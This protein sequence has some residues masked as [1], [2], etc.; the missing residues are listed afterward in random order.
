VANPNGLAFGIA[1]AAIGWCFVVAGLMMS[2]P[3]FIGSRYPSLIEAL[4]MISVPAVVSS[5]GSWAAWRGR[6]WLLLVATA[7][8]GLFSLVTGFSIGAG[9]VPS[10]GLL[11][12][13]F[14]ASLDA[15]PQPVDSDDIQ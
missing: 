15:D 11:V 6:R 7:V 9:F 5:V 14:I 10:F 12:W 1:V 4:A 8:V 2:V 3:M 13:A